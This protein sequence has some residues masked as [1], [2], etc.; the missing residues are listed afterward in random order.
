MRAGKLRHRVSVQENTPTTDGQGGN[1]YV[2]ANV[3]TFDNVAA[4]IVPASESEEQAGGKVKATVAHE[5]SMRYKAGITTA[6]R[7]LFRGRILAIKGVQNVAERGREMVLRCVEIVGDLLVFSGTAAVSGGQ[8][9]IAATG[10]QVFSGAAAVSAG[11]PVIAATGDNGIFF[12]Y[13]AGDSL[14][15]ATFTRAS[16]ARYVDVNGVS[17]TATTN[18]ARDGHYIGGVRTL[19]LEGA[20]TNICLQS[21]NFGTTWAASG[22]PTRSAAAHTAAGVTLDLIGDDDAAALEGYNQ[23]ITYTADGVKAISVHVKQ[24]TST[25]SVIQGYDSTAATSRLTAALTW[26]AGLP[27]ITLTGGGT[28]YGYES[29]A[30]GVYRLLFATTAVTAANV[31]RVYVY[32]A[33]TAAGAAANTGRLYAGGVQCENSTFPSSYIPT[34]TASV[35]RAADRLYWAFTPLPQAMTVYTKAVN[36]GTAQTANARWWQLG[37]DASNGK[38]L[39]LIGV[40][41]SAQVNYVNAALAAVVSTSVTN[42]L[43]FADTAEHNATI[44]AAGSVRLGQTV[45]GGAEVLAAASADQALEAAWG[46]SPTIFDVNSTATGGPGFTAFTSLKIA[47]GVQSLANMRSFTA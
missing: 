4:E 25:S 14:A 43:A 29:L 26:S 31:N 6:M 44:S 10:N 3:S 23:P 18:V 16:T 32:P 46:G 17:Q 15:S 45:N 2:W 21:E 34:T 33:T 9:V 20:R 5:V 27:V 11:Q 19:L 13:N 8:T 37:V 22:T 38:S 12:V 24:D 41:S 28:Y 30:D 35:T 7:V 36:L 42:S 47:R 39:R 40:S 1:T